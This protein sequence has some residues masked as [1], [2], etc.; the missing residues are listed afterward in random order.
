M[1]KSIFV[2]RRKEL[3]RS[4]H[5]AELVKHLH[6]PQRW[7]LDL[8]THVAKMAGNG[9]ARIKPA[10]SPSLALPWL[11]KSSEP[12]PLPPLTLRRPVVVTHPSLGRPSVLAVDQAFFPLSWHA[13]DLPSCARSVGRA[14]TQPWR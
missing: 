7:P 2:T 13:L 14:R 11:A 8:E 3:T 4:K 12:A 6:D 9:L 5:F 10:E 1:A